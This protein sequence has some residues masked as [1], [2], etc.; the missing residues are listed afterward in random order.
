MKNR[1]F[2]ALTLLIFVSCKNHYTKNHY[3]ISSLYV[4]CND[5]LK[6]SIILNFNIIYY[7]DSTK[8]NYFENSIQKGQDGA[9]DEII[10]FGYE[11][12]NDLKNQDNPKLESFESFKQNYNQ[13]KH[14]YN[15]EMLEKKFIITTNKNCFSQTDKIILVRKNKKTFK[16]D[17]LIANQK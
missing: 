5:T 12:E 15:G 17:T 2:L 10:Y 16:I 9:E 8:E 4:S 7:S 11:L 14:M 13:K 3:Y 1:F 6:N